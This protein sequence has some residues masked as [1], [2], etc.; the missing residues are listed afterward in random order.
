MPHKETRKIIRIGSM[1]FGIILP[2]SWLRYNHLGSGDRVEV[3]SNG[4]I[5]MKPERG[6]TMPPNEALLHFR[7]EVCPDLPI[8][9]PEIAYRLI[10]EINKLRERDRNSIGSNIA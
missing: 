7:K 1:S 4:S 2:L 9:S 8:D 3:I 10:E 6:G 5:V